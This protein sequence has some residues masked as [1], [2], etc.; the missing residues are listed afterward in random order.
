[1]VDLNDWA[2]DGWVLT[3]AA[4]IND[5]GDIVGTGYLNGV[6]HGFLLTNG[7]TAVPPPVN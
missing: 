3:S 4:A 1:M 7:S 6:P 5:N 2:T